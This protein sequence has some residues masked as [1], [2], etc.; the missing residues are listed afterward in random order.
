MV[1]TQRVEV[2]WGDS[3]ISE[4]DLTPEQCDK[5]GDIMNKQHQMNKK[6]KG[7]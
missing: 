7:K 5:V 3:I 2:D 6:Q 1:K 4:Y